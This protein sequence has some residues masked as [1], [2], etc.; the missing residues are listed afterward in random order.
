MSSDSIE[1]L[2]ARAALIAACVEMETIFSGIANKQEQVVEDVHHLRQLGKRLRGALEM[3]GEAKPCLRWVSVIGR[4]LGAS[5][6]ATV[7]ASTWRGL[8]EDSML[9]GS[10]EAAIDSLL[11]QEA[12]AARQPPPAGVCEWSRLA[13]EQIRSRLEARDDRELAASAQ[14]GAETCR[15]RLRKRLKRTLERVR[16]EDFHACRRDLKAWL[17]GMSLLAPN[18][19]APGHAEAGKLASHLGEEQDL[20]VLARWLEERGF[21]P[22]T[23]K[24]T[25]KHLRKRQEKVRRRSV[26]LIR[27]DLLPALGK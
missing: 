19:D 27:K 25:W 26:T 15:R 17:G 4:M 3:S 10:I 6:D 20:A 13:I 24:G 7:R 22:T 2:A 8:G 5:R 11:D 21:G 12:R 23:A 14:Q 1:F 9:P 16:D 18:L